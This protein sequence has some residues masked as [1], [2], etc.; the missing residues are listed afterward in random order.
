MFWEILFNDELTRFF[1]PG[2]Q[3]V[4]RVRQRALPEHGDD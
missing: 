3:D 1:R 4:H 2:T